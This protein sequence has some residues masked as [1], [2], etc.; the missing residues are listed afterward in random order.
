METTNHLN[1][2]C[3]KIIVSGKV[4]G[5][6]YRKYTQLKAKQLKLIGHVK[7]EANGNVTIEACG[8]IEALFE[9]K[10]WCL[11]GSPLS[12]PK[13]VDHEIMNIETPVIEEDFI[14]L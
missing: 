5:V 7:N 11:K 8:T 14:I 4:Q 10:D 12:K 6:F 1:I 13:T 9:L 3:W 2:Q